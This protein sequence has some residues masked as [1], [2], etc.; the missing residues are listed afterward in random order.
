MES[1][2]IILNPFVPLHLEFFQPFLDFGGDA[3]SQL[4]HLIQF[5]IFLR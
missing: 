2:E 4:T 5:L 3:V 1:I